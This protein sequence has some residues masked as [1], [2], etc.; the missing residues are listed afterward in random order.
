MGYV[1]DKATLD[2]YAQHLLQALVDEKKEK[3]DTA[4]EKGLKVHKEKVAMEIRK[5]MNKVAEKYL[6]GEGHDRS[7]IE[8]KIKII[9][10][11]RKEEM[12]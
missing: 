8:Q 2:A 10:A 3:L 1:V 11:C 4:Q 7:E 6:I 9:E 5:K 12:K